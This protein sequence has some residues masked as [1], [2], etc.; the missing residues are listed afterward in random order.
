MRPAPAPASGAGGRTRSG[1][2]RRRRL[3]KRIAEQDAVL[4]AGGALREARRRARLRHLLAAAAGERRAHRRLPRRRIRDFRAVADARGLGEALP[5]VAPPDG[6]LAETS[7]L[8][9]PRRTGTDGFFRRCSA[10]TTDRRRSRTRALAPGAALPSSVQR[11]R[12]IMAED[13]DEADRAL[14]LADAERLEDHHHASK[15]LGV[16]YEVKYVNIGKGEQFTPEFLAISPNNRM[17][18][19]VDP[20]GPGRQADLGLRVRRDPHVS[21]PKVR[22]LLSGRRAQARRRRRMA[23]LADRQCRPGLRP[24]QPFPQL[25]A[26]EGALRASSAS[27]TRRT[28]STAC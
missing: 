7:L 18:A 21:R 16:P 24:Q 4:D 8:L 5:D 28:G 26:G 20:E 3:Q 6:A 15:E 2:S 27:A 22:P 17:P 19:I 14:L 9:T 13:A 10:A 25:R 1:G 23:R 12:T 11:R